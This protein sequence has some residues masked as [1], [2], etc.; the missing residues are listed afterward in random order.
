MNRDTIRAERWY[1]M[2]Y[3]HATSGDSR[4][5]FE[6]F[7]PIYLFDVHPLKTGRGILQIDFYHAMYPEGVRH[8]VYDLK[9]FKRTSFMLMAERVDISDSEPPILLLHEI[10]KKWL[11]SR[12][13]DRWMEIER[14]KD[15]QDFLTEM[16]RVGPKPKCR[17]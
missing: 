3:F 7:S 9:V 16:M 6:H 11:I 8:K 14:S 5:L 2:D 1:A 13:P 10:T 17:R 12:F 15:L 4:E